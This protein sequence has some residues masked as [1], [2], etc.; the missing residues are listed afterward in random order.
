MKSFFALAAAPL[1]ASLAICATSSI[2]STNLAQAADLTFNWKGDAGYSAFGSFSYD[3]TTT[4]GIISESG[5]GATKALQSLSVSFFNPS[6][7]LIGTNNEVVNG[8]SS[9]QYFNFNFDTTTGNLFGAFDVG[10]GSGIG[11][12]F[13]S[14]VEAPGF[15]F[16]SPGATSYLYQNI[17]AD[18]SQLLDSS[19]NRIKASAV[20]EPTTVLGILVIGMLGVAL[21]SNRVAFSQ[22][23]QRKSRAKASKV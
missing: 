9:N 23:S 13:L 16:I 5:A 17:T 11:D 18:Y 19:T 15:I 2:A 20:P 7:E 12:V 8:V 6:Q 3:E 22:G 10:T 4:P 21:S 14:N 1:A